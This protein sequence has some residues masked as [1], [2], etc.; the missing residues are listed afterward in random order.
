MSKMY[1][2]IAR[3]FDPEKELTFHAFSS[4][5]ASKHI[6]IYIRQDGI[7]DH[8]FSLGFTMEH[9]NSLVLFLQRVQSQEVPF[10]IN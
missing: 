4:Q 6:V 8:I 9:I 2:S 1:T 5:S 10:D 7:D 3:K